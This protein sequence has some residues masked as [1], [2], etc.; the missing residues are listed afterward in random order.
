MFLIDYLLEYVKKKLVKKLVFI[1]VIVL[2][3]I[4]KNVKS[5][6]I[7]GGLFCI[8]VLIRVLCVL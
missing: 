8:T 5:F 3:F 7:F 2:D 4:Y 6:C 1:A